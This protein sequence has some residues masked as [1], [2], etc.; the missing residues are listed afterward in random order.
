LK[1]QITLSNSYQIDL[2]RS[3]FN[4]LLGWNQAVYNFN[5]SQEGT[6]SANINN[7]INTL[8]IHC[9]V[10]GASYQNNNISDVLYT[11]VPN[12]SPGSNISVEGRPTL[13]YLPLKI[14]DLI[15]KIRMYIT[16]QKNNIINF[17]NEPIT[18][19]LHLRKQRPIPQTLL[20]I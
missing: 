1:V 10:V 2:T 6:S 13:I 3:T 9:D 16:D 12:V 20:N 14:P 17:Q 19:L 11:F 8:L 5:G 7:S 15:Y 4:N 18:Y